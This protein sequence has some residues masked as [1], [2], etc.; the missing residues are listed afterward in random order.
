M[1]LAAGCENEV[2][3][4][5]SN[6]TVA[7]PNFPATGK[8]FEEAPKPLPG[9]AGESR[10]GDANGQWVHVLTSAGDRTVSLGNGQL[11]PG[12][13]SRSSAPTRPSPSG[14]PPLRP[15]VACETQEPPDL[16]TQR[17]A[18]ASPRWRAGLPDTAAAR[19]RATSARKA[20]G[21]ATGCRR[22]GEASRAST[23]STA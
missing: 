9:L 15:D 22:A 19:R 13:T 21:G 10:N 8:V 3:N 4:P 7:D 23:R 2:L 18:R 11:R 16:R 1:R 14:R 6:D 12:A 17:R 5:W 20:R